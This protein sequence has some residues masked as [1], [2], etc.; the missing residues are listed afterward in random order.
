MCVICG[1]SISEA[2]TILLLRAK[3]SSRA[4]LLISIEMCLHWHQ[5]S[6]TFLIPSVRSYPASTSLRLSPSSSSFLLLLLLHPYKLLTGK[7]RAA[8]VQPRL[9]CTFQLDKLV[10]KSAWKTSRLIHFT[11]LSM[12]KDRL[13]GKWMLSE[14]DSFWLT[15]AMGLFICWLLGVWSE[16]YVLR[17]NQIRY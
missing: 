10:G 2:G 14:M 16:T 8:P 4:A 13:A 12:T 17:S 1:C 7:P 11:L 15:L 3:M 6:C 5:Y 9:S